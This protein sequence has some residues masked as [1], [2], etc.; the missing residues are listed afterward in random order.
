MKALVLSLLIVASVSTG[1]AEP[2]VVI[3][4]HAEKANNSDKDPDL[5]A[6]G[7][8]RANVLAEMLK[9]SGIVQIFTTEF[10]RTAKTAAPTARALGINATVVPANQTAQ[11]VE[12]LHALKGNA[13][14]VGH[15]NSIPDLMKGLGIAVPINIEENDYSQLFIVML[16]AKPELLQLHY[17]NGLPKLRP[18]TSNGG[19]NQGNKALLRWT[20][21][22]V[23]QR[24]RVLRSAMSFGTNL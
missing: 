12:K 17:S 23:L 3:V 21:N 13:L 15:G 18:I 16:G 24:V 22:S 5:S 19:S 14:V 20:I 6:A 8:A 10:K 4:R 1:S 9:D 11:L 7:Q 2:F